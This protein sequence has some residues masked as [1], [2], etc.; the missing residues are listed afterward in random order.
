MWQFAQDLPDAA[1]LQGNAQEIMSWVIL[2]QLA[3]WLATVTYFLLRERSRDE[4]FDALQDLA[5]K[6]VHRSNRAMEAV[7]N[8]KPPEELNV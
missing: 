5:I 2:A 7:A 8:I 1:L 3:L 4:K 6:I